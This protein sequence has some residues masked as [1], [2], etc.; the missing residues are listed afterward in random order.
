[1][2]FNSGVKAVVELQSNSLVEMHS[3]MKGV[4]CFLFDMATFRVPVQN[5][6]GFIE[7][8]NGLNKVFILD[9]QNSNIVN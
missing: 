3:K 8:F 9:E 1:M 2:D 6:N 7:T 5:S 4:N